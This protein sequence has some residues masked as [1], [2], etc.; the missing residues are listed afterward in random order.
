MID[1]PPVGYFFN[2]KVLVMMVITGIFLGVILMLMIRLMRHW[3]F[4]PVLFGLIIATVFTTE[5]YWVNHR[6]W[7]RE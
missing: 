7:F 1:E 5:A 6:N 4:M 3:D 2:P